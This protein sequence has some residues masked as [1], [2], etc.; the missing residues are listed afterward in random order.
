MSGLRDSNGTIV[1]DEEEAEADIRRIENAKSKLE[2]VKNLLDP[3]KIDSERMRGLTRD[4]LEE[5][6]T[7][8]TANLTDWQNSCDESVR[9]IR[10]V[11]AEYKRID[12]EYAAKAK[13]M[14]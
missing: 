1:I 6:F 13:E 8:M 9:Y 4:A 12:K 11:V 14:K 7:K 10:H 5:V 3:A 2:D